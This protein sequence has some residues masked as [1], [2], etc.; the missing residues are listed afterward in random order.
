MNWACVLVAAL[1]FACM[2]I[3]AGDAQ[4]SQPGVEKLYI[5]NCGEGIAGDIS[6]WSPGVNEGKS[7]AFV[8]TCYLIKHGQGWFLWD[9]GLPDALAAMPKGEAPADPRA[10]H[11]CRR[12]TFAAQL[13]QLGIKPSDIKAMS[14]SHSHP[15]HVGNLGLFP[16]GDAPCAE[17]RVRMAGPDHTP[18]F[19]PEHP[20]TKLEGTTTYSVT[21]A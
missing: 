3:D 1:W 14:V 11:W 18:R 13:E 4:T 9:T 12:K 8:E 6:R 5:F 20:V 2:S 21:A 7:K 15:D 19:K 16:E 17:S 10:I